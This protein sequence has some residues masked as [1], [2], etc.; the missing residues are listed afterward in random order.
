MSRLFPTPCFAFIAGF[1][2]FGHPAFAKTQMSTDFSSDSAQA[3]LSAA[4]LNISRKWAHIKYQIH[5]NGTQLHEF[6]ALEHA[7]AALAKRFPFNARPLLWQGIVASEEAARANLFEKLGYAKRAR[8]WL[9]RAHA[10]NPNAAH[11]GVWLSLGVLYARVPGF[12]FG[13]GSDSKAKADLQRALA[14]DPD[15]LDANYFYGDFL[16]DHGHYAQ[17]MVVLE[18][19]LKAPRDSQRPIWDGA[20]RRQ[21]RELLSRIMKQK[22][23]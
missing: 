21:I 8:L 23:R 22:R 15:G 12:P 3:K 5:D 2:L 19:G 17:A 1:A 11:G 6:R 9:E 14:L 18:H 7:A 16:F 4:I 10:I 13:F 20:R